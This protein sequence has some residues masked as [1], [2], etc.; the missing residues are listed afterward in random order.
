MIFKMESP[1]DP[2]SH[3]YEKKIK[4]GYES[5]RYYI[6][7]HK[8]HNIRVNTAIV[9]GEEKVYSINLLEKKKSP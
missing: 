9:M 1:I 3:N 8:G 6:S 2:T 7:Q 5:F 4:A